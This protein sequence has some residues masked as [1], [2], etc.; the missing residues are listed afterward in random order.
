MSWAKESGDGSY[1]III[2]PCY[3]IYEREKDTSLL[4]IH[5]L[6]QDFHRD[7]HNGDTQSVCQAWHGIRAI[8]QILRNRR[9]WDEDKMEPKPFFK[10]EVKHTEIQCNFCH[11]Q[12]RWDE[13]SFGMWDGECPACGHLLDPNRQQRSV[14]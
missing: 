9:E 2:E 11:C 1:E 14:A 6:W 8:V 3:I 5:T 7:W 12:C 13:E 10:T 4:R